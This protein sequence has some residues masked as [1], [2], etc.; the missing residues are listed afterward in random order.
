MFSVERLCKDT[1]SVSLVDRDR[2]ELLQRRRDG[3]AMDARPTNLLW[4]RFCG[5]SHDTLTALCYYLMCWLH[6]LSVFHEILI[7]K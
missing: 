4:Y 5:E 2:A 7:L 1:R 6:S 3:E